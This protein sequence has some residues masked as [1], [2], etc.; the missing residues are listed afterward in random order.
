MFGLQDGLI[1]FHAGFLN[2]RHEPSINALYD[3]L[4]K[5]CGTCGMRFLS[6]EDLSGH[7]EWHLTEN[8]IPSNQNHKPSCN[9]YVNAKEWLSGLEALSVVWK[10]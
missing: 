9:W 1:V 5:Q 2:V 8:G 4:S 3:D 10:H 6:Q 7:M